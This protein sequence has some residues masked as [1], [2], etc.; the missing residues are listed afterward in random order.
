[1]KLTPEEK[2]E[3]LLY[4]KER[5]TNELELTEKLVEKYH[6]RI[7]RLDEKIHDL[8]NSEVETQ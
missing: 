4:S 6:M 3:S 1:M 8:R 5:L 7:K 2:L